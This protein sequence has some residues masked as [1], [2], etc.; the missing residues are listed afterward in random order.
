MNGWVAMEPGRVLIIVHP[1]LT[2]PTIS[3]AESPA[4]LGRPGGGHLV[5]LGRVNR[6]VFGRGAFGGG[7]RWRHRSAS[8]AGALVRPQA[9]WVLP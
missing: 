9:P 7:T 6:D 5:D 4:A 8:R 2:T 3:R 1:C